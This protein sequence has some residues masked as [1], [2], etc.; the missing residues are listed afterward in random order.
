DDGELGSHAGAEF[1][2]GV[3]DM[4]GGLD[5]AA[6]GVGDGAE[7]FEF[8]G[9]GF[10]GDGGDGDVRALAGAEAAGEVFG[11]AGEGID[12]GEVEDF[13]ESGVRGNGLAGHDIDGVDDAG[14]GRDEGDARGWVADLAALDD[15]GGRA[16]FDGVIELEADVDRAAGD[17][18]ADDGALAGVNLD[19]AEGED[20]FL[21]VTGLC[22]HGLDTE[23]LH[24]GG[25]EH[26]GVGA[27]VGGPGDEQRGEKKE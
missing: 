11:H 2:R 26:D 10:A 22:H 27:A 24:A 19:A 16:F 18:A 17:A 5:G 1:E 23:V 6:G 7:V 20:G 14:D 9:E 3:G 8:G 13:G 12:L 15:E 21:E 4:E 25:V